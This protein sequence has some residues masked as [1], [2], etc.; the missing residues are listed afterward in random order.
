MEIL[1]E[2]IQSILIIPYLRFD[3]SII[4]DRLSAQHVFCGDSQKKKSW[5]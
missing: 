3:M 1:R 4:A 5:H 2:T